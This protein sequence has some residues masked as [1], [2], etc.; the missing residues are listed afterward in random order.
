MRHRGHRA[1]FLVL[2]LLAVVPTAA[3]A[4]WYEEVAIQD[5]DPFGIGPFHS[6]ATGGTR[7]MG[8]YPMGIANP[9]RGR[10][11][12]KLPRS[13]AQEIEAAGNLSHVWF[14]KT[15]DDDSAQF[16]SGFFRERS[17]VTRVPLLFSLVGVVNVPM[18]VG[19]VLLDTVLS[20]ADTNTVTAGALA[21][22]MA[23]GG[24]FVHYV[25]IRR[26]ADDH[27]YLYGDLFYQVRVQDSPRYYLI[28]SS[29]HAL[30]VE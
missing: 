13:R 24:E 8:T 20:S 21:E 17:E 16:W 6:V 28:Y 4:A 1:A 14:S 27:P 22:L 7:I 18:G 10:L 23:P 2:V 12:V 26:D 19:A 9:A 25:S 11:Y 5:S 30:K 15:L 29:R 3:P